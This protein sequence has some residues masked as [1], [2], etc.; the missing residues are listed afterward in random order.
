MTL[1]LKSLWTPAEVKSRLDGRGGVGFV[2]HATDHDTISLGTKAGEYSEDALWGHGPIIGS[3]IFF[4]NEVVGAHLIAPPPA[5]LWAGSHSGI[6]RFRKQCYEPSLHMAEEAGLTHLGLAALVP[7]ATNHGQYKRKVF[8]GVMTTGHAATVATIWYTVQALSETLDF[9]PAKQRYAIFGAA[10]S[11]GSN[12]VRWL[13]NNGISD[14][15]LVDKPERYQHLL[16][17][18]NELVSPQVNIALSS[19]DLGSFPPFDIGIIATSSTTP[20]IGA[21]FLAKAP[22]WI[23]DSHPRAATIEAEQKLSSSVMYLECFLRGPHGLCQVFPFRLPTSRD[24]YS[25]FAEA[26]VSWQMKMDYDFAV[27]TV[28]LHQIA[29]MNKLLAEHGFHA[30]PFTGKGGQPISAQTVQNVKQSLSRK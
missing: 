30:G 1:K 3:P 6:K 19:G 10:G 12:T 13:I 7:F 14:L 27:G 20:W 9:D 22:I 24:C 15:I 21:E 2:F 23:D 16:A 8:S 5:N 18:A 29:A 25:C 28:K 4:E 11:I 26:F 17:L